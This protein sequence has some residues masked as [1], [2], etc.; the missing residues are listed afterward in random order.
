MRRG[1]VN[2]YKDEL[3]PEQIERANVWIEK[4]LKENSITMEDLLLLNEPWK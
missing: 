3:K 4:I 1:Q 2:G